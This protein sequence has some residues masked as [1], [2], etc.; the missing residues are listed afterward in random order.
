MGLLRLRRRLR[1]RRRGPSSG[2][3]R[4]R[5]MGHEAEAV[6]QLMSWC[7]MWSARFVLIKTALTLTLLCFILS[8]ILKPQQRTLATTL[9]Y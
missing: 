1:G 8:I 5:S 9:D 6:H 3:A 2:D 4:H 7:G